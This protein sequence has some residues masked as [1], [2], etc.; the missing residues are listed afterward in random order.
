MLSL[1][2]EPVV[3]GSKDSIVEDLH[4]LHDSVV[5]ESVCKGWLWQSWSQGCRGRQ[6]EPALEVC[7]TVSEEDCRQI[8]C[9]DHGVQTTPLTLPVLLVATQT[10][11]VME[12]STGEGLSLSPHNVPQLVQGQLAIS[13]VLSDVHSASLK[14]TVTHLGVEIKEMKSW[15]LGKTTIIVLHQVLQIVPDGGCDLTLAEEVSCSCGEKGGEGTGE[16][17]LGGELIEW[18]STNGG[19]HQRCVGGGAGLTLIH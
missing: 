8:Q 17:A 19:P 16:I 1:K 12:Y 18:H 15:M 14:G 11:G 7:C 5:E 13:W 2:Q 4:E 6:V 10:G 3:R 9:V